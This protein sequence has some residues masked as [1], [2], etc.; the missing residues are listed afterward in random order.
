MYINIWVYEM[1]EKSQDGLFEWDSE[2]NKANIKKHRLSFSDA[3]GIFADPDR[4]EFFDEEHS[5]EDECR[6]LTLG[7]L[8]GKVIIALVVSTDKD[9]RTRIISARYASEREE[10]IYYE[11]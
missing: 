11:E 5:T 10:I 4:V 7:R 9:G 2:K 6:Y 1:T 8:P 3:I